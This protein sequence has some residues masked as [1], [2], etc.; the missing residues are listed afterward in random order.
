MFASI[1]RPSYERPA[2]PATK[3]VARTGKAA[4]SPLISIRLRHGV[5]RLSRRPRPPRRRR[6]HM[7]IRLTMCRVRTMGLGMLQLL[8]VLTKTNKCLGTDPVTVP[9]ASCAALRR[10]TADHAEA[11]GQRTSCRRR[12]VRTRCQV[13]KGMVL[14]SR[15][16]SRRSGRGRHGDGGGAGHQVLPSRHGARFAGP[17]VRRVYATRTRR[18]NGRRRRRRRA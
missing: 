9:L 13:L 18:R 11:Q 6:G 14:V 10:R 8:G 2:V 3:L 12:C 17:V 1:Q 4:R 7:A 16:G 5:L 15:S